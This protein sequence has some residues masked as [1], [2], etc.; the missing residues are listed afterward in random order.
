M[1]E[2]Y[3]H[4]LLDYLKATEIKVGLILNFG[5]KPQFKRQIFENSFKNQFKSV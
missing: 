4:Q 1:I 2:E 5:K 3:E